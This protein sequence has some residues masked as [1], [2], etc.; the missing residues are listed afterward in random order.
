MRKYLIGVLRRN[1]GFFRM[2]ARKAQAVAARTE[3]LYHI[4]VYIPLAHPDCRRL[5]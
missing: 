3:T 5:F 4:L 2:E 1:A